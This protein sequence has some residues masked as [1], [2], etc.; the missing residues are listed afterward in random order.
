MPDANFNLPILDPLPLPY[1]S[2]CPAVS[3]QIQGL[4]PFLAPLRLL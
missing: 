2:H 1:T 4:D 3:N